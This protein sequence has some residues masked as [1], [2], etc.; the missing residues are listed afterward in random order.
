[1][2]VSIGSSKASN[3]ELPRTCACPELARLRG[4]GVSRNLYTLIFSGNGTDVVGAGANAE[5]GMNGCNTEGNE[6]R[7]GLPDEAAFCHPP[8]T[9]HWDPYLITKV[10][11]VEQPER[12]VRTSGRDKDHRRVD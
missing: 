2:L 8:H 12:F 9:F 6:I 5:M 11:R 7:Y 10:T 1:M 4:G 3:V